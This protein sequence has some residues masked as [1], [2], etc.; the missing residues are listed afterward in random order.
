MLICLTLLPVAAGAQFNGP[1]DAYP[2]RNTILKAA[3]DL[4][5]QIDN[6]NTI[7]AL[8]I[9][10]LIEANF[11][12][13][14]F[15]KPVYDS[16]GWTLDLTLANSPG[17][18][19]R[20]IKSS[21]FF[22]LDYRQN[23]KTIEAIANLSLGKDCQLTEARLTYYNTSLRPA[24]RVRYDATFKQ[25]QSL[26][27][28]EPVKEVPLSNVPKKNIVRI[29]IIDTGIDYNHPVL[30]EKSRP[31]LGVD[32]ITKGR[33]PYD[34]TNS[35][36]NE[37]MGKHFS[38]GTAV[39]DIATRN[40]EALI[41]P[42]RTSNQPSQDGAAVEYLAKKNV[43]L[44]NISQ[45]TAD[46]PEWRSLKSAMLK[47]PEMLFIVS[48]GNTKQNI[49]EDPFYPASFDIPNM[50]VVAS[51]NNKGEL[52]SFSNYGSKHVHF[53]A[54]GENVTAALAG[55]GQWSVNGTS[56]AA[57][58][59]TNIAAQFL[60]ENPTLTAQELRQLLIQFAKPS[61]ELREKIKYGVLGME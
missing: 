57:P 21:S 56:F 55:G 50:L 32:L 8:K 51:V 29:G 17:G 61:A 33:P 44:V 30:L 34:Y 43:R 9:S 38:H 36:Q 42:V 39:A 25:V 10:A 41:I 59:V 4:C 3:V 13:P 20:L 27:M 1:K 28:E 16:S 46:K 24:L 48:S 54:V 53:A 23:E 52:S 31:M 7:P 49:D 47:H 15:K 18:L 19:L 14:T 26:I 5:T 60:I 40:I 12:K 58:V 37:Q 6:A 11:S 45:G 22:M 35:I 2:D